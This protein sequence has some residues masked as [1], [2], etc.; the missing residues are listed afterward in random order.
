[1]H[2]SG[3]CEGCFAIGY[4][5]K[6]LG[7]ELCCP[8]GLLFVQIGK[9]GTLWTVAVALKRYS[10]LDPERQSCSLLN[11]R[12]VAIDSIANLYLLEHAIHSS[13]FFREERFKHIGTIECSCIETLRDVGRN[14]N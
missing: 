7:S 13:S 8:W 14:I 4:F 10:I 3:K 5:A 12:N 6:G 1:M 9:S 2:S 11:V